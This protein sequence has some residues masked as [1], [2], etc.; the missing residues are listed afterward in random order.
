MRSHQ[1]RR[2]FC[3]KASARYDTASP[4][5]NS[6]DCFNVPAITQTFPFNTSSR[7]LRAALVQHKKPSDF[8]AGHINKRP[9]SNS[10]VVGQGDIVTQTL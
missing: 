7:F 3:V 4:K 9:H 2:L 8:F 5:G 1:L 10:F 6:I